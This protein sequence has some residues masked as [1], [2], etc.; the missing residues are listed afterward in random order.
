MSTSRKFSLAILPIS[1]A[2]LVW[3]GAIAF[4]LALDAGAAEAMLMAWVLA[5]IV[6]LPVLIV[7]LAVL[8]AAQ[9]HARRSGI[10]PIVGVK[11]PGAGR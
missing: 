5:F 4:Q 10:I 3:L 6:G 8:G 2:A 9:A 11:I 7:L 1:L